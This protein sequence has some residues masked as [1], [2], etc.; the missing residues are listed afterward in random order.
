[1]LKTALVLAFYRKWYNT[2][3]CCNKNLHS[4]SSPVHEMFDIITDQVN[5]INSFRLSTTI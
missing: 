5:L 2:S 4:V 3:Q 1:M